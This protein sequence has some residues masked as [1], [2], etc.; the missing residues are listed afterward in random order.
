[1]DMMRMV[2]NSSFGPWTSKNFNSAPSP[3]GVVS[4]QVK[5]LTCEE[6]FMKLLI[7]NRHRFLYTFGL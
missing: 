4:P 7:D 2:T 6:I 5:S 1:M 3:I